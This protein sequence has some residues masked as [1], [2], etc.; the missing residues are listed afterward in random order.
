MEM[1]VMMMKMMMGRSEI[2]PSP[3]GLMDYGLWPMGLGLA[4]GVLDS[5]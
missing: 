4:Y 5:K 2:P 3:Y 1:M